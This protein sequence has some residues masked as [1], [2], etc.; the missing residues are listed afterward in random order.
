M[1]VTY[2]DAADSELDAAID[3]YNNQRSGLGFEFYDAIRETLE[4][5]KNYPKAWT[6]LSARVRRCQ[7]HRFP[8]H[9]L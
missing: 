5:I 7:V 8:Q 4:R 2:V 6:P 3:Y 9:H 1:N